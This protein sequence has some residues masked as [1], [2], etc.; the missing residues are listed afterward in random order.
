M[1]GG[2]FTIEN[3]PEL[4]NVGYPIAHLSDDTIFQITKPENRW[5]ANKYTIIEQIC[6]KWVT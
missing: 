5:I 6:M 1:P 4:D 2:N 3:I